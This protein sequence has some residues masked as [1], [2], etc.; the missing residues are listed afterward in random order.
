MAVM[1]R[2]NAVR[3]KANLIADER[4]GLMEIDVDVHNG[5]ATLSG[6]ASSEEEKQAAEELAY[7]VDGIIEVDNII[8]VV[9]MNRDEMLVS[10]VSDPHLGYGP[11]EGDI[12]DTAFGLSGEYAPPG[13]GAVASE[14]F[15][16]QYSDEE[17][18][19]EV[20][21]MLAI[22]KEL[23]VSNIEFSVSNQIVSLLGKVKTNDELNQLRDMTTKIRGALGVSTEDVVADNDGGSPME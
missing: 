10:E 14:Q 22:E 5:I 18:S 1:D 8:R 20:S 9:S 12:G 7:R 17:I 11:A 2:L 15:P 19:E 23:D 16:D 3:I 4:L 21:K 6:D 13:P